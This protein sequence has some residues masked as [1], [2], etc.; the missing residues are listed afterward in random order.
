MVKL[1]MLSMFIIYVKAL[2]HLLSHVCSSVT[3]NKSISV[4]SVLHINQ[5]ILLRLAWVV[6]SVF[7]QCKIYV[8]IWECSYMYALFL[9]AKHFSLLTL[10]C[11]WFTMSLV[12]SFLFDN[13]KYIDLFS[14]LQL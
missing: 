12:A 14:S 11:S 6:L 2:L 8:D 13:L 4:F 9:L 5:S 1:Q 10:C 3:Y 7:L